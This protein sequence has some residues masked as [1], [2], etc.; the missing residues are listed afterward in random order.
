M[1]LR[2]WLSFTW[3]INPIPLLRNR[4]DQTMP[5]DPIL[6]H[7]IQS[8]TS[9]PVSFQMHLIWSSHIGLDFPRCLFPSVFQTKIFY[10]LLN[11]S[12]CVTSPADPIVLMHNTI[13]W[14]Y[15]LC[16]LQHFSDSSYL[17]DPKILISTLFSNAINLRCFVRVR[18][19]FSHSY[20]P[21]NSIG[22]RYILIFR[23]LI[24]GVKT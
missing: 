13:W 12:V 1:S 7:W 6:T 11:S 15:S 9:H 23:F 18:D 19:Y 24:A 17:L 20:K 16:N 5:L 2:T 3:S 4:K 10:M 14:S 22:V 21:V 8:I